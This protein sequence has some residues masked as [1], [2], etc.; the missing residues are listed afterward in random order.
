MHRQV[1]RCQVG[2]TGL[3]L[4]AIRL[5]GA[6]YSSPKVDLVRQFERDLKVGVVNATELCAVGLPIRGRFVA[7]CC[8]VYGHGWKVIGPLISENCTSLG[9]LGLGSL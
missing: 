8:G 4:L 6:P 3:R 1:H 7:G 9:I 2:C 5:N